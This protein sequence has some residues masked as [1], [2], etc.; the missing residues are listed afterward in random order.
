MGPGGERYVVI[1]QDVPERVLRYLKKAALAYRV[2][3]FNPVLDLSD[4]PFRNRENGSY[5]WRDCDNFIKGVEWD[6]RIKPKTPS[7]ARD[8]IRGGFGRGWSKFQ[9]KVYQGFERFLKYGSIGE[10]ITD[11]NPR[12]EATISWIHCNHCEHYD[13]KTLEGRKVVLESIATVYASRGGALRKRIEAIDEE[14]GR[15]AGDTQEE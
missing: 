11:N 2:F 5:C 14:L 13:P 8:G 6:G 7:E 15:Q 4:V 3:G 10:K 9:C 12:G 1:T